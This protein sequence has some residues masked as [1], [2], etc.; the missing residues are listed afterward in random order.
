MTQV[1][2]DWISRNGITYDN[3]YPYFSGTT[4]DRG[5]CHWGV[6]TDTRNPWRMFY[7]DNPLHFN[8]KK[9]HYSVDQMVRELVEN[10]PYYFSMQVKDDFKQYSGGVYLNR[11]A[12]SVGGHAVK[13][14]GFG[15]EKLDNALSE[16]DNYH[17]IVANSWGPRFGEQGFFRISF[18]EVFGYLAS[19]L[20]P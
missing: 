18:G 19:S 7:F 6:C 16:I 13:V 17:W 1:V 20:T 12:K 9:E 5:Q 11:D 10:G 3:C 8:W 4:K 15:Y 2:V 14:V